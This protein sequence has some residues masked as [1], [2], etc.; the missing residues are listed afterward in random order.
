MDDA[1]F[2][3]RVMLD[4]TGT[5]PTVSTTRD[6][7]DK[8]SPQKRPELVSLTLGLTGP[9]DRMSNRGTAH[10]ARL[11]R[12][13][14]VPGNGPDAQMATRLDPWLQTQFA[15]NTHYDQLARELILAKPISQPMPLVTT[16]ALG[17]VPAASGPAVLFEAVG[18]TPVNL[19]N[20]FT[21]AFLGVRIGCAQ[22]H[23]H[24]FA[25]W[26]QDDFWGMAAFFAGSSRGQNGE[27]TDPR[28]FTI[29][30][31]ANSKQY[32]ARFLWDE[33]SDFTS[34][35]SDKG[36]RAT[37]ADWMTSRENPNFSAT[38]VN[39]IWQILCGRGLTDAV[40]DLDTASPAE[41]KML[42]ELAEKFEAAQY[43]V[44][45]LVAGI[46]ISRTYQ[47]VCPVEESDAAPHLTGVRPVKILL[48]EQLY[49]SLEQALAL[50]VSR[51]D[52]GPRFNGQRTELIVRMNEALGNT[53][54]EFKGGVPQALL[55]MN[56]ELVRQATSL[57]ESR[58]LRAVVE[59]PFLDETEKLDTLFLATLTRF[60]RDDEQQFL[61][62]HIRSQ[63]EP[64]ARKQAYAEIL[65]GLLN[66]PEF[67]LSR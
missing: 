39:R 61:M 10:F 21:R 62:S 31:E 36:A 7:L 9:K 53:P 5:I 33:P 40:D 34:Q 13:M 55:L 11:F 12:R 51:L 46:C 27:W 4:L 37:F 43:D 44:R 63:T 6:F 20:S 54:E 22:C 65:W 48:P 14:L 26:T 59:A 58:T 25:Q 15:S 32:S 1:T 56:G 19:A 52:N 2:L 57:E 41:R 30:N 16:N 38:A 17:F 18:G 50:P 29:R 28:L 35:S 47:R 45:W 49:D 8:E 66:S 42:N 24:P 64:A 3:R 67:V 23:N 60:P